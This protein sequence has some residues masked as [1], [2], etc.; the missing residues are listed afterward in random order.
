M[1]GTRQLSLRRAIFGRN[2]KRNKNSPSLKSYRRAD[3][4]AGNGLALAVEATQRRLVD[5][6]RFER[7]ISNQPI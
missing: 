1:G 3:V 4:V 5:P 6:G 7:R 2:Q